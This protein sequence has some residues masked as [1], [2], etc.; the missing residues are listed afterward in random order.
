MELSYIVDGNVKWQNHFG[1]IFQFHI[2]VKIHLTI[3][4]NSTPRYFPKANENLSQFK[5]VYWCFIYSCKTW[6]NLSIIRRWTAKQMVIF[7]HGILLSNKK[8]TTTQQYKWIS[9]IIRVKEAKQ[10]MVH[11]IWFLFI[12]SPRTGKANLWWQKANQWLPRVE[13][14]LQI[15]TR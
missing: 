15:C 10:K 4:S 8:G 13:G 11:N 14:Q 2:K 9:Q 12:Y 3:S 5:N 6:N 7:T 1:R